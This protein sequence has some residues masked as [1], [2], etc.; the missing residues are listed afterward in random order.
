M[1]DL[2]ISKSRLYGKRNDKNH[3]GLNELL[4]LNMVRNG[5]KDESGIKGYYRPDRP[6]E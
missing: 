6:P 1:A 4:R 5:S 3:G 2:V